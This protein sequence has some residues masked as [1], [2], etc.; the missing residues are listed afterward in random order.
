MNIVYLPGLFCTQLEDS[1]LQK[2]IYGGTVA[3]ITKQINSGLFWRTASTNVNVKV[4]DLQPSVAAV[5]DALT[6]G[7]AHKVTTVPY[8]WRLSPALAAS[9]I[10]DWLTPPPA[11]RVI[12]GHS[13]G[14]LVAAALRG[15]PGWDSPFIS[16]A[17]PAN[18]QLGNY[19][20]VELAAGQALTP[21]GNVDNLLWQCAFKSV[22]D[23]GAIFVSPLAGLLVIGV[24]G[25]ASISNFLQTVASWDCLYYLLPDGVLRNTARNITR[26]GV[27]S[28]YTLL[29]VNT[30]LDS[31]K[32]SLA[33]AAKRALVNG[34]KPI[35][36]VMG[37]GQET[38]KDARVVSQAKVGEPFG[39]G[40]GIAL[41]MEGGAGDG[42]VLATEGWSLIST[43]TPGCSVFSDHCG[44]PIN[45]AP[46]VCAAIEKYLV[47]S[48]PQPIEPGLWFGSLARRVGQL[49]LE[50]F[51]VDGQ[52]IAPVMRPGTSDRVLVRA[53]NGWPPPGDP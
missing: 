13:Y 47:A 51:D 32:M 25:A 34:N 5:A 3:D 46:L 9:R 22:V 36:E 39:P 38:P 16:L 31:G 49:E 12:V 17:T 15:L 52:P 41:T 14:G 21:S 35:F 27:T 4:G 33:V 43:E 7:G 23:E 2:T 24:T 1:G 50:A 28:S 42:Y 20:G 18:V 11:P 40:V 19:R 10:A 8:D 53:A 48:T 30:N 6:C 29:D 37:I 26:L 44:I 45:A